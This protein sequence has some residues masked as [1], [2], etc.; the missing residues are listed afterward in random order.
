VV[1]FGFSTGTLSEKFEFYFSNILNLLL[2]PVLNPKSTTF[3]PL[4]PVQSPQEIEV[5]YSKKGAVV[6]EG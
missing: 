4:V 5:N 2:V 6:R 1:L 3:L